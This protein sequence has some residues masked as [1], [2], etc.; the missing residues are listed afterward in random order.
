M[1]EDMDFMQALGFD[2]LF[3]QTGAVLTQAFYWFPYWG[4]LVL[5]TIFWH[6]WIHYVQE[7]YRANMK[8][9][10]L[11]IKLPKEIHKTPMAMEIALNALYQ[12][13]EGTW[14]DKAWKGKLKDWFSLEV[15]S[16]EGNIKF[17]IRTPL[18]YKNVIEAQ[19]YAQYPDV[20]MHEVPD[21]T[22]YVDYRGK[23]GDWEVVGA[24]YALSKEDPYPIKTYV[25]YGLD[26]EGIKEE[27]KIDPLTAV[28]EYLGSVGPGEQVWL[29]ILVQAA[30]KRYRKPDG[31][32]GDWKDQGKALIDKLTKRNE[33]TAEGMPAFKMLM[34]T[35]GE[36]EV[37]GALERSMSKLGFDC[38]VRALYLVKKEK[39]NPSNIKALAGLLRPFTTNNL[40]GFKPAHLT[41]GFNYPWQ[42][43]NNIRLTHHRKEQFDAYK[44]RSWFYLPRKLKPFVLTIEELA[45][46]YHFP[47]GVAQTPTF[48]RIPS[49]KGEAPIDLPV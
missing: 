32:K 12:A 1:I 7:R 41:A 6:E 31:T 16:F 45:T 49:R 8:W 5:G 43:F 3:E 25:D 10:L 17:F 35:K 36:Q 27:F 44:Q 46:I 11:E 38:G 18:I 47:G 29:Q 23:E 13:A 39:F 20:E 48:G 14:F 22:R 19:I 21:Y 15:A 2:K 42:D 4:P 37:I 40:N 28:I 24:E 30:S 26:K 34:M 9:V 33:K